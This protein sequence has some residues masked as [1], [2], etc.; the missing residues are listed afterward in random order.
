V[1]LYCPS[2]VILQSFHLVPEFLLW[3]SVRISCAIIM[4]VRVFTY[5]VAHFW[6]E[7]VLVMHCP[8]GLRHLGSGRPAIPVSYT[9]LLYRTAVPYA[10]ASFGTAYLPPP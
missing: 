1:F 7:F 9:E 6:L 3:C 4:D 5:P 2:S 8:T 10:L